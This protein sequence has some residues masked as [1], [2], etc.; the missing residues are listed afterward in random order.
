MF[1]LSS[2]LTVCA[3]EELHA[4]I[5]CAP[6]DRNRRDLDITINY[7]FDGKNSDAVHGEQVYRM[8]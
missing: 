6:N 2:A 5:T 8:R 1:Y 7:D 3:G 4:V